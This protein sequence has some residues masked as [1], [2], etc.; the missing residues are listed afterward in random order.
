MSAEREAQEAL[1]EIARVETLLLETIMVL[2]AALRAITEAK[3]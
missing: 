1:A 2:A 3:A